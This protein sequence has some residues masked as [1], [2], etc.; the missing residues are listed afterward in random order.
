MKLIKIIPIALALVIASAF[1][2][3][4]T[5]NNY[6]NSGSISIE[7]L[8]ARVKIMR[9]EKGMAYIYAD[10][11]H[12]ALMAQGFITAQDRLFQMELT[13]MFAQGRICELA[14]EKAKALDTRMRTLGFHRNAKKHVTI[15]NKQNRAFFQAYADG[16]NQYIEK[17]KHNHH[18]EFFLAGIKPTGWEIEDIFSILFILIIY[19]HI[20]PPITDMPE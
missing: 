9:D 13:R 17:Q 1:I 11:L 18:V 3:I 4:N 12:D 7:G 15:L 14:G 2:L 19:H 16:V 6:Q 8:H 10:D 5:I 20:L